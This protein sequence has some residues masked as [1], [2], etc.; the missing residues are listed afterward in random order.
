MLV[1]LSC[2]SGIIIR[3]LLKVFAATAI[4]FHPRLPVPDYTPPQLTDPK[5]SS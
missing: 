1:K 4:S 2:L 3:I 5:T